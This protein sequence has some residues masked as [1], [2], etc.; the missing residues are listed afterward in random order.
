LRS[1]VGAEGFTIDD[2]VSR[3]EAGHANLIVIGIDGEA[4]SVGDCG[5]E[6]HRECECKE[7][8]FGVNGFNS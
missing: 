4:L 1:L 3:K 6:Q 8:P 2:R 7:D 5:K